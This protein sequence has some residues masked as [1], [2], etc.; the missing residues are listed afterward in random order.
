M[1]EREAEREREREREIAMRERLAQ[2]EEE[3]RALGY[4]PQDVPLTGPGMSRARSRSDTPGS[5]GGSG[6]SS[7][8]DSGHSYERERE[9]E[10]RSYAA[11]RVANLLS[12]PRESYH[13]SRD[14]RMGPSVSH[15]R[16]YHSEYNPAV[17]SRKRSRHDMEI[18]EERGADRHSPRDTHGQGRYMGSAAGPSDHYDIRRSKRVHPD[19]D[20]RDLGHVSSVRDEKAMDQDD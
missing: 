6:A 18:D 4:I 13:D 7:H 11:P 3:Y 8:P 17:D 1:L 2:E 16:S 12:N 5:N 9:R 14:E 15:S 20:D 10:R 19:E